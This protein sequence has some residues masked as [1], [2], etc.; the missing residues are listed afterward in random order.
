ML[1]PIYVVGWFFFANF[2][3]GENYVWQT[4]L[5]TRNCVITPHRSWWLQV[6]YLIVD[7]GWISI[8]KRTLSLLSPLTGTL[9]CW[10]ESILT[11]GVR[12]ICNHESWSVCF[13]DYAW[14]CLT[15]CWLLRQRNVV[16]YSLS[17]FPDDKIND[18]W[19]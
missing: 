3:Y 4:A 7:L 11:I 2:K 9:I 19:A 16:F 12:L 15:L 14:L 5:S 10:N 18:N 8:W 1:F 6:L 13:V 17:W